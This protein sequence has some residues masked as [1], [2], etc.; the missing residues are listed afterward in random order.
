M[1]K[2]LI[3]LIL[4]TILLSGCGN[5]DSDIEI[6]DLGNENHTINLNNT[7]G[8]NQTNS[9]TTETN[10]TGVNETNTTETNETNTSTT[11]EV[12][13]YFDNECNGTTTT[14]YSCIEDEIWK[15]IIVP[16]CFNPGELN[17]FCSEIIGSESTEACSHGCND[18]NSSNIVC[19]TDG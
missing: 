18:T 5:D 11:E 17:S 14:T 8:T 12:T 19:N 3:L 15:E 10:Q 9:T 2:I 1:K 13:C 16:T 4:T 6:Q 7:E